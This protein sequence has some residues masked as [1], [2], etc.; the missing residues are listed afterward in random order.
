MY[1]AETIQRAATHPKG[2]ME[3][4]GPRGTHG[5]QQ[6]SFLAKKN[7]LTDEMELATKKH[8]TFD[9]DKKRTATPKTPPERPHENNILFFRHNKKYNIDEMERAKTSNFRSDTVGR[10]FNH[11][12]IN[13]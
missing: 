1:P 8:R 3:N 7:L 4:T 6:P 2:S 9:R 11:K 10:F 13:K 12:L 5:K